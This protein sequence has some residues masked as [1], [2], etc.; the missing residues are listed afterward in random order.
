METKLKLKLASKCAL[1]APIGAQVQLGSPTWQ[2]KSNM[3]PNWAPKKI[4][5]PPQVGT[6]RR[7]G[8]HKRRYD[9]YIL[10]KYL[11][12]IVITNILKKI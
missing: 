6:A 12:H 11:Y 7:I 4:E 8:V 9:I 2:Y 3:E 10:Y 5:K 1:G